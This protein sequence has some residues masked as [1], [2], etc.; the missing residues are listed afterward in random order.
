MCCPLSS[1][2][3]SNKTGAPVVALSNYPILS[4]LNPDAVWTTPEL[5]YVSHQ[6]LIT[7]VMMI[8]ALTDSCQKVSLD[9]LLL[10]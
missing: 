3:A 5:G 1:E 10:A 2:R 8:T 7:T 4:F 6:G 9:L